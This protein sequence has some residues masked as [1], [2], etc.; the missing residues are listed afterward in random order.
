[1]N[2]ILYQLVCFILQDTVLDFFSACHFLSR[3]KYIVGIAIDV[4]KTFIYSRK[5][6]YFALLH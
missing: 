4:T 2:P 3:I 6:Q 1:M 5:V